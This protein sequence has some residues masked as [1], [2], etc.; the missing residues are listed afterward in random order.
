MSL[1]SD[2][3]GQ[4]RAAESDLQA[5]LDVLPETKA[6]L[7]EE[8]ATAR[9]LRRTGA[10]A[11]NWFEERIT[12][13]A[14]AWVL[15]S[16]FVRFC[17]DNQLIAEPYLTCPVI[18]HRKLVEARFD[19]YVSS[20][21]NASHRGWL[22]RAFSEIGAGQAGRL[23]FDPSHNPL[24]Q[25]PLSH[26][27]AGALIRFWRECDEHGVLIHDFTDPCGAEGTD[28]W[29]TRFLGDLYQDLSEN[30]RR[31]Y[32]LLQ[33]PQFVE[34]YI[35]DHTLE[36]AILEFGHQTIRL[37]DPTCGSGHFLLD[38]FRR[39]VKL[40]ATESPA[41]ERRERVQAALNSVHGVDIN[42]FAI[43][44]TRFRLI[45]A[46]MAAA[47][48]HTF[49]EAD[50]YEWPI[51]LAVGDSLISERKEDILGEGDITW[52]DFSFSTEDI[53]EHPEILTPG[54]YHVVVGNPPYLTPKDQSLYELYRT[55]YPACSGKFALTIPFIVRYFQLARRGLDDSGFVGI[56]SS[57]S[58]MK[59]E[60]GAKLI[61]EFLPT[62]D[63]TRVVDT[64]GAYIPSHGTP[65]VILFGRNRNRI[66]DF[67]QAII[68]LRN[69]PVRPNHPELGAVWRSILSITDQETHCHDHWTQRVDIQQ[70]SLHRFP[71]RLTDAQTMEI[72][73]HM[74]ENDSV[75]ESLAVKI[76]FFAITGSNEVFL[77]D[78]ATYQRYHA[79]A[80]VLVPTV[81]GS[82]IRDWTATYGDPGIMFTDAT[83]DLDEQKF[84]NL[85]R[86]LWPYRTLLRRRT[87]LPQSKDGSWYR[88][89]HVTE[90]ED[91]HPWRIAFT[92][93]STHNHFS[94][95]QEHA[96]ALNSAPIIRFSGAT[97]NADI[98]QLAAILNSSLA[99]FW[100]KQNSNSKGGQ[101]SVGE[102]AL[103]EP[104]TEF[105]EFASS[106]L[107]KLP[108]PGDISTPLRWTIYAEAIDA[109]ARELIA[110]DPRSILS[111]K[112]AP[113]DRVLSAA[114]ARWNRARGRVIGLQEELDWEIY[115]KYGLTSL[116][117]GLIAPPGAIPELEPGQRAFEI[118]MARR[119]ARGEL[120]TQWFSMN[121]ASPVISLPADWPEDY[122][123]T[124][125]KRIDFI[126]RLQRIER[127]EQ[128]MF[129]RR[130]NSPQWDAMLADALRLWLL[131]RMESRDLWF[132]TDGRPTIR[133]LPR[134]IDL[135]AQD[136]DFNDVAARYAPGT[137][138]GKLVADL[139]TDQ[140]V[141]FL[142]ALRYK[143]SGLKKREV[144]EQVWAQQRDEDAAPDRQTRDSIRK[145]IPTPPQYTSSDFLRTT[146]W[147]IRGKLDTPKERFIAYGSANV[148]TPELYGWAGW[149][150]QEQAQ[151][152]ADFVEAHD[153]TIE[154]ATPLL[155]GLLE[156]QPRLDHWHN[157]Y[158]DRYG[159]SPA[160]FFLGYR[161][162]KRRDYG[163]TDAD[164]RDWRPPVARRGRPRRTA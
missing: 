54:R 136:K 128:P 134:L 49:A 9:R 137:E 138:L 96:A 90:I 34:E 139:I 51:H 43:A 151:A 150:Y 4:V 116:E 164:L 45:L 120:S 160:A 163:L 1:L 37:I 154:E 147:Q 22:L 125:E 53:N 6:Q 118:A 15:G 82:D 130:W 109:L 67:T 48:I 66:S 17:E 115:E 89:S 93:V 56:L 61:E 35:L 143:P 83:T 101:L 111:N 145:Y 105:Y 64:S 36:P 88:W 104:W 133:T 107:A 72:L 33:T 41:L 12:Q 31:T 75:L 114:R 127:V 132:T 86:I 142:A 70:T 124:V 119:I 156:L 74:E 19:S 77:S 108:L 84:P 13:A 2:L 71:W 153:L 161:E 69:E 25:I 129:K 121:H 42:P 148:A 141:P 68:C 126:E 62:V 28:G 5:Q 112:N 58:F 155:A 29:D 97:S 122:R 39:L 85:Y 78:P 73:N 30:A 18:E 40:W 7:H 158:D 3:K 8:W 38:A 60:F 106:R 21:P 46:A 80:Q 131:N 32:A 27:G 26:D 79:E 98:L 65:T 14:V 94:V 59:R 11:V 146:H 63:L 91:A 50:R 24:Y 57:N 140:H 102:N 23:L 16:V 44:I 113:K 144:W 76:G 99:C 87:S 95:L 117:D 159:D 162:M 110:T 55:L 52:S 10:T 157:D 149:D 100:I 92:W 47:D 152:L 123:R 81:R 135:L 20:D 103:G